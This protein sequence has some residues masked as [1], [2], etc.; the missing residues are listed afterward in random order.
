MYFFFFGLEV[1]LGRVVGEVLDFCVF[2]FGG[3]GGVGLCG[4]CGGFWFLGRW[5]FFGVLGWGVG[6]EM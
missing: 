4:W 5:G 6:G 2:V 3:T 1:G